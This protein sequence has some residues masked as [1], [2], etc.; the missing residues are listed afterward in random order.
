MYKQQE[1]DEKT[2]PNTTASSSEQFTEASICEGRWSKY[3]DSEQANATL[4]V[5]ENA[6]SEQEQILSESKS[7][8]FLEPSNMNPEQ[9][10]KV[11]EIRKEKKDSGMRNIFDDGND[12]LDSIVY[13]Q[14]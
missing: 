12:D 1:N 3:L 2:E 10:E 13:F 5:E 4:D 9:D 11:I 6:K 14:F 7:S 8:T